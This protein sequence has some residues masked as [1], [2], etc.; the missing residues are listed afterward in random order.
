MTMIELPTVPSDAP[1]APFLDPM[2][3]GDMDAW[4]ARVA[5]IRRTQPVL[6]VEIDGYDPLWVLTRHADVFEIERDDAHWPN[7]P[8]SILTP[9][10]LRE[11]GELF[12]IQA[13]TLVHL[14]GDEHRA[15]RHVVNDWFKPGVVARRQGRV[16]D[17]ADEYVDKMRDLG[18]AC[19]FAVD[20][21]VPTRCG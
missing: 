3:W 5:E 17:L 21:A 2:L 1:G 8:F 13:G 19:D 7:T 9:T 11:Q 4:H 15:H 12:G 14:D 10:A 20:I 18:G 16:E 6:P